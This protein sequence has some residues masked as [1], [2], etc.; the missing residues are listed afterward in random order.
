METVTV[1]VVI[2]GWNYE[3]EDVESVQIFT[4]R[5]ESENYG[6]LLVNNVSTDVNV[7]H[8]DYYDIVERTITVR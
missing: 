2:G 8:Y 7:S 6:N 4:T 5:E 3:G 1:F